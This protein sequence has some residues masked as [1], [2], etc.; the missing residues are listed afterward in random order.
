MAFPLDSAADSNVDRSAHLSKKGRVLALDYGQRRIGIAI[1]DELGLTASPLSTIERTNRRDDVRRLR[2][3][4]REHTVR[5]IVVGLPLHLDGRSSEMADEV[6]RFASRIEKQ[7]GLP[8]E[9]VDERLTSWDAA[10]MEAAAR[11]RAGSPATT[12]DDV[13]AAIFLRDYLEEK[14]AAIRS[15]TRTAGKA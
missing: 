14:A 15:D 4:V 8:V 6:K 10:Q 9:L 7:L 2:E 11:R 1:S 5:K 13:A 12:R 3:I